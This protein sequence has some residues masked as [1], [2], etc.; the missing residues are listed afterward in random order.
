MSNVKEAIEAVRKVCVIG[1]L[2]IIG[3]NV[4]NLHT[5]VV[6]NLYVGL[7]CTNVNNFDFADSGRV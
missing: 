4:Q 5:L 2:I 6:F 7:Q 3:C 1:I